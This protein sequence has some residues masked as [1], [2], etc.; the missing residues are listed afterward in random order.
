MT[1][2]LPQRSL[3][4]GS[5][6]ALVLAVAACGSGAASPAPGEGSLP[7]FTEPAVIPSTIWRLNT[8]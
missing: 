5:V 4:L 6:L 3:A 1:R 2:S 7:Y 8:T